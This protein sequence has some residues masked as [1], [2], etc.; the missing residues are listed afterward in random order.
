[1]SPGGTLS[2]AALHP[3]SP[4]PTKSDICGT[5]IM[6]SAPVWTTIRRE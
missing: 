6:N 3:L 4:C 2:P 5:R 1:M